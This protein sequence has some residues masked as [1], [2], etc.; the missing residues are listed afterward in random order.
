MHSV[1][2]CV[3]Q[4]DYVSLTA[5]IKP[6]TSHEANWQLLYTVL[7]QSERTSIRP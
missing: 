4:E 3:E 1:E 2:P 6:A 5:I 7:Q